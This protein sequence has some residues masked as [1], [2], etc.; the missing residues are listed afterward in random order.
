MEQD[1]KKEPVLKRAISLG[2]LIGFAITILVSG[3]M[4]YTSTQVRMN[5]LELRMTNAEGSF[6]EIKESLYRIES[7]QSEAKD[8]LNNIKIQ[9][10]NKKDR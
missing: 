9:L 3:I 2:E 7:R 1:Q 10:N 5:A 8:E 4:F 6:K